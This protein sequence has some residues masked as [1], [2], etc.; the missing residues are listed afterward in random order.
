MAFTFSL[1]K[2]ETE[3]DEN[4]VWVKKKLNVINIELKY[5]FYLI[6][7]FVIFQDSLWTQFL[8]RT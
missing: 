3:Q 5:I 1:R 8:K 4:R 6:L 2:L 7:F